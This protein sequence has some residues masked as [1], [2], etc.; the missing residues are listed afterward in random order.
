MPAHWALGSAPW[1]KFLPVTPLE[2]EGTGDCTK[3]ALPR[4]AGT[5]GMCARPLVPHHWAS[6]GGCQA[7]QHAHVSTPHGLGEKGPMEGEL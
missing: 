3:P 1:G 6:S 7:W 2:P 4:E 5:G